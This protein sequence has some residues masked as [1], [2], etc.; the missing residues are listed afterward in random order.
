[1]PINPSMVDDLDHLIKEY[2]DEVVKRG[3]DICVESN[4]RV[5][6]YLKGVVR[7][8]SNRKEESGG[9]SSGFDEEAAKLRNEGIGL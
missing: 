9:K 3:I 8:G 6:K 1:M 5:M 4:V 7:N 2:G